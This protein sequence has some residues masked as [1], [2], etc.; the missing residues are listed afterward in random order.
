MLKVFH[1]EYLYKHNLTFFVCLCFYPTGPA[2]ITL[3]RGRYPD[4]RRTKI[5]LLG[6]FYSIMEA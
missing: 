3:K 4:Q 6:L 5:F 2:G 1:E